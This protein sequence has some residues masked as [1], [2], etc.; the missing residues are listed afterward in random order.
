M[1]WQ[2]VVLSYCIPERSASFFYVP[3]WTDDVGHFILT[4]EKD[5]RY[6]KVEK[7]DV[8]QYMLPYITRIFCEGDLYTEFRLLPEHFPD[9]SLFESHFDLGY[10][11]D[12][13]ERKA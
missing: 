3:M 11:P 9:I 13:A 7:H 5:A 10:A 1:I 8:P 12:L 6:Q 2:V 4:M